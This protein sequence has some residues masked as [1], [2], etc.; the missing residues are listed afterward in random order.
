M[1]NTDNID[2]DRCTVA[3]WIGHVGRKDFEAI[4]GKSK[5]LV[6]RAI[7]EGVMPSNGFTEVSDFG[8]QK[9]VPVPRHL[10]RWKLKPR[11]KQSDY[12]RTEIQGGAT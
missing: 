9:S 11:G 7:K 8:L 4:T 2:F 3:E 6:T 10:F 12:D 5:Q 1:E